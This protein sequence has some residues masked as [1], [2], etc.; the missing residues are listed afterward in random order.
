M[1]INLPKLHVHHYYRPQRSWG[2]VIF[3]QASV[4]LFTGGGSTSVYAGIPSPSSRPPPPNKADPPGKETPL[5]RQ[6]PPG[7]VD[8]PARQTPHAVHAGRYAQQAGGM[9]PTGMQFLF[10]LMVTVYLKFQLKINLSGSRIYGRT[11]VKI[12]D[13]FLNEFH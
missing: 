6:T 8:P 2:K 1:K 9:H 12:L 11:G 10:F 4:I 3:S 7:K 13:F 5:A